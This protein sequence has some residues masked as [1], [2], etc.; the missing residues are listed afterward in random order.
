MGAIAA[1]RRLE[2]A[3]TARS[4]G[5]K[6]IEFVSDA[7]LKDAFKSVSIWKAFE[8][9]VSSKKPNYNAFQKWTEK[10]ELDGASASV[11]VLLVCIALYE[12]AFAAALMANL[13]IEDV[14]CG[15]EDE[16]GLLNYL[17]DI[18][19]DK[20]NLIDAILS[21]RIDF[22]SC[23]D[24]DIR[25]QRILGN[26]AKAHAEKKNFKK[27][28]YHEPNE[29]LSS[30]FDPIALVT[31]T[32]VN[33]SVASTPVLVEAFPES[34]NESS[35]LPEPEFFD[36]PE[37]SVVVPELVPEPIPVPIAV[38]ATPLSPPKPAKL[39][40]KAVPVRKPSVTFLDAV[41][42]V[43]KKAVASPKLQKKPEIESASSPVPTARPSI[44][45]RLKPP[46]SVPISRMVIT[47]VSAPVIERVEVRAPPFAHE[48]AFETKVTMTME[49]TL[50]WKSVKESW[51][52]FERAAPEPVEPPSRV[53]VSSSM[54]WQALEKEWG[55]G[56]RD[57]SRDFKKM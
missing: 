3:C 53:T 19:R 46:E 5:T 43:E 23:E 26:V 42:P 57:R 18:R 48:A 14:E 34:K 50:S 47:S 40:E 56:A 24:F 20:T 29:S 27:P 16:R 11:F 44:R 8:A 12:E 7:K 39:E 32:V 49:S 28:R 55:F 52:C 4:A 30:T 51:G 6:K 41:E 45:S 13:A 31:G 35:S 9:L 10:Y 54:S 37:E 2:A 38:V 15:D 1:S 25:L 22:N 33:S 36:V 21:M 17:V